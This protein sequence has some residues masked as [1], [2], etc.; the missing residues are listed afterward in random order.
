M[1][2]QAI[3]DL[4]INF[5]GIALSQ[6]KSTYKN[7]D[8]RY[9]RIYKK[10]F[11]KNGSQLTPQELLR[12]TIF[13]IQSNNFNEEEYLIISTNVDYVKSQTEKYDHYKRKE[14]FCLARLDDLEWK[15]VAGNEKDGDKLMKYKVMKNGVYGVIFNPS[16]EI[17]GN[18]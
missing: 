12:S 3:G 6:I 15:C 18:V 7:I 10:F 2:I 16:M 8:E 5:K 4:N 1:T 14:L 13:E 11:M 9:N 17:D